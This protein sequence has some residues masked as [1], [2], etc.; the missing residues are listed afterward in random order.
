MTWKLWNRKVDEVPSASVEKAPA[1]GICEPYYEV[2]DKVNT[3]SSL[4]VQERIRFSVC[5]NGVVTWAGDNQ[6]FSALIRDAARRSTPPD[7][8]D[9]ASA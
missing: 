2:G 3:R 7:S 9:E 5:E 4:I 1:V 6:Q 8:N